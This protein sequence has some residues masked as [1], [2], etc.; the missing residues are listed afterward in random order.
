MTATMTTNKPAPVESTPARKALVEAYKALSVLDQG[1]LLD[2]IAEKA[3]DAKAAEQARDAIATIEAC[4]SPNLLCTIL[5][6]YTKVRFT[7]VASPDTAMEGL[8]REGAW[9][10]YPD[11]GEQS[12]E[13]RITTTGTHG[14][15]EFFVNPD[16]EF[17]FFEIVERP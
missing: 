7:T 8:I 15:W 13:R 17:T 5:P 4:M 2:F 6:A 9:G 11:R 12:L 3:F 16:T 14:G 1:G 10:L